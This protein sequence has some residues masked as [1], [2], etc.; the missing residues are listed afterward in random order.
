M[1][2]NVI[3]LNLRQ[4]SPFSWSSIGVSVFSAAVI[5]WHDSLRYAAFTSA[6]SR[7]VSTLASLSHP[8]SNDLYTGVLIAVYLLGTV[9]AFL[10]LCRQE[11][12]TGIAVVGLIFDLVA[13]A[14]ASAISSRLF[15]VDSM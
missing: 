10:G 13:P 1:E 4:R 12:A 9:C 15:P 7:G 5:V 11:R 3:D 8:I 2:G 14:V 6:R